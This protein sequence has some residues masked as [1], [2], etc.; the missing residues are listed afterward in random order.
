M[1]GTLSR[2]IACKIFSRQDP[3]LM[4]DIIEVTLQ[5]SNSKCDA[6]SLSPIGPIPTLILIDRYEGA[7]AH[8]DFGGNEGLIGPGAK[9][10]P[11]IEVKIIAGKSYGVKSSIFTKSKQF[12]PEKGKM[13]HVI[14]YGP[15]DIELGRRNNSDYDKAT[16]EK[17]WRSSISNGVTTIKYVVK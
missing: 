17:K 5:M 16:K 14:N 11:G 1:A 9:P 12:K 6:G 13:E 2:N 3:F 15:F 4:C 8:E 10:E 7:I